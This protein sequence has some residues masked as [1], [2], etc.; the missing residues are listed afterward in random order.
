M[1]WTVQG[2]HL[3]WGSI[4]TLIHIPQTTSHSNNNSN[5]I[6]MKS[7]TILMEWNFF[8]LKCY[9]SKMLC[10]KKPFYFQSC[11]HILYKNTQ[12]THSMDKINDKTGQS[13][14]PVNCVRRL[15]WRI[16]KINLHCHLESTSLAKCELL[17]TTSNEK[18]FTTNCT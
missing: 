10:I 7:K 16:R 15:K 13:F 17:F 11:F 5:D 18:W 3:A 12:Y 2:M 8:W 9:C 1:Q 6:I 14:R 4:S